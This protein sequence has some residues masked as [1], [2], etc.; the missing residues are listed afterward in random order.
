[1]LP[2]WFVVGC[3]TTGMAGATKIGSLRCSKRPG[4]IIL[5]S[6]EAPYFFGGGVGAGAIASGLAGGG[7]IGSLALA[8]GSGAI[9]VIFTGVD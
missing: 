9:V 4:L 8:F 6:I 3:T 5:F 1:V 7:G 2:D